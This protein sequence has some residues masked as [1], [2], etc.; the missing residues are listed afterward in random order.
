MFLIVLCF[1]K[2][3][4][5]V[6]DIPIRFKGKTLLFEVFYKGFCIAEFFTRIR[7]FKRNPPKEFFTPFSR[8][9]NRQI[10]R[11]LDQ[12]RSEYDDDRLS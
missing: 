8:L 12:C 4:R 5:Q 7:I 3:F 2:I 9:G 1:S 11:G 6:I 10:I